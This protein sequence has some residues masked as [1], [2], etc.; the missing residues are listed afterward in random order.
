M[1]LRRFR[2]NVV[3]A[4]EGDTVKSVAKAM[5]DHHVGSVIV[6]RDQRPIGVITD[7]D[8]AV[9]VVAEGRDPAATPASA[10]VTYAPRVIREDDGIETAVGIMRNYGVRRLP[11][12]DEGGILTG[13]VTADDLVLLLGSELSQLCDGV[14]MASDATDSR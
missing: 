1:S 11:L 13:I 3:T 14:G 2:T 6:V 12:V 8:L 7:R 10:V 4:E 5:A 9:R